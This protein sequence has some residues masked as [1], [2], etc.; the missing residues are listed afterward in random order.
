[1]DVGWPAGTR[2][3]EMKLCTKCLLKKKFTSFPEF[4][5]INF[6]SR[7]MIFQFSL[8]MITIYVHTSYLHSRA[9]KA[10]GQ[11]GGV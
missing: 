11:V 2:L 6:F 7:I 9:L 5:N 1:M 3:T 4:S 10:V 8:A